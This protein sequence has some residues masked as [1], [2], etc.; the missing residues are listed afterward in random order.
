MPEFLREPPE[1]PLTSIKESLAYI[2]TVEEAHS[3]KVLMSPDVSKLGPPK[4]LWEDEPIATPR[5]GVVYMEDH[6]G[7]DSDVIARIE[8]SRQ[9]HG[10]GQQ[11]TTHTLIF[12][13]QG[14][15]DLVTTP[16]SRI[17]LDFD[18]ETRF[19]PPEKRYEPLPATDQYLAEPWNEQDRIRVVSETLTTMTGKYKKMLEV[20]QLTETYDYINKLYDLEIVSMQFLESSDFQPGDAFKPVR[21]PISKILSPPGNLQNN[22][23]VSY[24]Q[25]TKPP[26]HIEEIGIIGGYAEQLKY[27]RDFGLARSKSTEL[28]VDQQVRRLIL[29]EYRHA[30]LQKGRVVEKT[31]V[32]FPPV[33]EL[34]IESPRM[35]GNDNRPVER[36]VYGE[37]LGIVHLPECKPARSMSDMNAL[38]RALSIIEDAKLRTPGS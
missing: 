15:D 18:P 20:Q 38:D 16:E 14:N 24:R 27:L 21:L 9:Q 34:S 37:S 31:G 7:F 10:E 19:F 3:S 23:P 5:M 4:S 26:K 28:V 13:P 11:D 30:Q 33:F 17:E 32:E 6:E 22:Q 25:K 8:A 29:T 2:D 36:F 1:D 12:V 35:E